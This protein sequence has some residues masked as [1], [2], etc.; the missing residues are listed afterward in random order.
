[1]RIAAIS[2]LTLWV[3]TSVARAEQVAMQLEWGFGPT[4]S[5]MYWDGQMRVMK[6]RL[7][8]M[9]A[10]SF[11]PDRHDRMR[12]PEFK[13]FTVNNGTD[14]MELVVDG[15]DS[16]TVGL[17]SLQGNFEWKIADLRKKLELSFPGKDKGRLVVRLL[18]SLGDVPTLLSDRNTQDS[19]PAICRL[20]D[21]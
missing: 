15:D 12:P 11:E 18:Q 17:V 13:S 9:K 10:V 19:D 1:M 16:T 6:G 7:I 8:S 14:G 21:N 3:V 4:P 5:E 2:I 20:A